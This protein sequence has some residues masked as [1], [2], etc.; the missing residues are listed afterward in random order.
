MAGVVGG[1]G[2]G[3]RRGSLTRPAA[4]LASALFLLAAACGPGEEEA[5]AGGD[6]AG[7]SVEVA[8]VW[9]GTEQENF[10]QVLAAFAERTGADVT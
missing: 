6:L 10:Q 2:V 9:T 5:P 1:T 4:V 3:V 7:R 8:A